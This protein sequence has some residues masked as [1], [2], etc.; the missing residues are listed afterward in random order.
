MQTWV[1]GLT[2]DDW[3]ETLYTTWL[4]TLQPLLPVSGEGYPQ[5]MQSD[6]GWTPQSP[7]PAAARLT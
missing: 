6:G 3:I 4:Y 2:T 5:F 7:I 1:N